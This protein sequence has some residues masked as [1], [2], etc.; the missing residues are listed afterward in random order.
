MLALPFDNGH[1]A[2]PVETF[3]VIILIGDTTTLPVRTHPTASVILK[4]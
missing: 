1:V 4:P 3:A 2:F